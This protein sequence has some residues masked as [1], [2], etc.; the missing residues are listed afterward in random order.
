MLFVRSETVG[1]C[2]RRE[3]RPNGLKERRLD[4]FDRSGYLVDQRAVADGSGQFKNHVKDHSRILIVIAALFSKLPETVAQI[5]LAVDADALQV[6]VKDAKGQV[7]PDQPHQHGRCLQL[8]QNI[9][10]KKDDSVFEMMKVAGFELTL[11]AGEDFGSL[12]RDQAV[13]QFVFVLE[14]QVEGAFGDAGALSDIGNGNILNFS[15]GEQR[16]S[17]SEQ[18][19]SFLLFFFLDSTG[20]D[21]IVIKTSCFVHKMTIGQI[22]DITIDMYKIIQ[23]LKIDR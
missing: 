5:P 12:P 21:K 19:M 2:S 4:G 10:N 11:G 22:L 9:L 8:T 3:N 15:G 18:R 1:S 17:G 6:T 23:S 13:G 20:H 16:K 7:A 14:E